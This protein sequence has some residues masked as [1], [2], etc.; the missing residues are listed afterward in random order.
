VIDASRGPTPLWK[1]TLRFAILLVLIVAVGLLIW[2]GELHH[3]IGASRAHH[4][5]ALVRA[6]GAHP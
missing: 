1:R 6:H 5:A 2:T 4:P 3:S